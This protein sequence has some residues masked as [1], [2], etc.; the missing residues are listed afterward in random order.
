MGMGGLIL[1]LGALVFI[2]DF[3]RANSS[4]YL[5]LASLLLAGGLLVIWRGA[6][7]QL[8]GRDL[9]KRVTTT[10]TPPAGREIIRM[11][12]LRDLVTISKSVSS[13][14]LRYQAPED[15]ESPSQ[16]Y[17]LTQGTCYVFQP[18]PP[19]SRK[20]GASA[21]GDGEQSTSG[22][23]RRRSLASARGLMGPGAGT[24]SEGEAR[25]VARAVRLARPK[26]VAVSIRP[27]TES[28]AAAVVPDAPAILPSPVEAVQDAAE[29]A[30]LVTDIR[31][32][33]SGRSQERSIDSWVADFAIARIRDAGELIRDGQVAR[34]G[35]V[36]RPVKILLWTG[37]PGDSEGSVGASPMLNVS[38]G[39]TRYGISGGIIPSTLPMSARR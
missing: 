8:E 36:L 37:G 15:P 16:F 10:A 14:I 5:G 6:S 9:A 32:E 28:G 23:Q 31:R 20:N 11:P 22:A 18:K 4:F 30:R 25:D 1:V 24:L 33:L 13:P 26:T 35:G 38:A 2:S 12:L 29:V 17:L 39:Y 34:A 7:W 27:P 21:T 19:R 3:N